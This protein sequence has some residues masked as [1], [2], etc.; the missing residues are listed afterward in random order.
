VS[1]DNAAFHK[2]AE[3]AELIEVTGAMLLF[4]Q[5][6]SPD[7]NPVEPDFPALTKWRED[8]D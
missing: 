6:Y 8:Q 1:M 7:F 5:P 2:S 3:T 4:L